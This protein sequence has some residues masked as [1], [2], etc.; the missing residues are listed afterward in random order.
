MSAVVYRRAGL[1]AEDD[2]FMRGPFP[3]PGPETVGAFLYL[4]A[5]TDEQ[6]AVAV[7]DESRR[8]GYANKKAEEKHKRTLL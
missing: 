5:Q 7:E 8:G 1:N 4:L 3:L 2:L 6:L